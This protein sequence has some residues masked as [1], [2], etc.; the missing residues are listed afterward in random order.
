MSIKHI[1]HSL[2]NVAVKP[3]L[4]LQWKLELTE[5]HQKTKAKVCTHLWESPRAYGWFCFSDSIHSLEKAFSLHLTTFR[6]GSLLLWEMPCG[7]KKTL[8]GWWVYKLV[9]H[10]WNQSGGPW[11]IRTSTTICSF[12]S[13][14]EPATAWTR[15]GK[16]G[17]RLAPSSQRWPQQSTE[18]LK[19]RCPKIDEQEKKSDTGTP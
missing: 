3:L 8:A 13:S 11:K 19:F 6:T 9:N 14:A 18:R 5:L 16:E 15:Y 4:L 2:I 12:N 1:S 17:S 7:G 10:Y